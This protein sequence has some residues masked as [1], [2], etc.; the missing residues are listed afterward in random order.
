MWQVRGE[1][2]DGISTGQ[3][4]TLSVARAEGGGDVGAAAGGDG[5]RNRMAPGDAGV[6]ILPGGQSKLFAAGMPAG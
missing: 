4:T 5:K 3:C 2:A 1:G 6:R